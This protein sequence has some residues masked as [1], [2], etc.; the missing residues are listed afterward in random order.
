MAEIRLTDCSLAQRVWFS[1]KDDATLEKA[2]R[3][4]SRRQR[5][6]DVLFDY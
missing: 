6:G 5:F 2:N 3:V 1:L 4:V